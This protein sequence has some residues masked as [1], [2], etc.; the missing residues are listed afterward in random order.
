M[1]KGLIRCGRCNATMAVAFARKNGRMYRYYLYLHALAPDI[2]EAILD[3]REPSGLSLGKLS[4]PLPL[5]WKD[6]RVQLGFCEPER[7][8]AATA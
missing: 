8:V 2:V 4:R 1:L 3:G 7:A 6:Q 5:L